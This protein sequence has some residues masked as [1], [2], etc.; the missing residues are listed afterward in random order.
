MTL[1]ERILTILTDAG[2]RPLPRPFTVASLPFEFAAALVA[3]D[4]GLDLIVIVNLASDKDESSVIRRIQALARA[5]DLAG[6]RRPLTAVLVGADANDATVEALSQVCRV[7][8]VGI[9]P[10]L[11]ADQ[12]LRDWLAV[13]LPLPELDELSALADW[14][15]ELSAQLPGKID[16]M[17]I[18]R[19]KKASHRNGE[20]VETEFAEML[21]AEANSALQEK[22]Q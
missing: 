19:F 3:S 10:D 7:L 1:V 20:A 18:E 16:S 2:Y 15:A 9:P 6:S 14:D 4:K 22:G 11:S 8:P 12:S 21:R 17:V 13:L 5:L